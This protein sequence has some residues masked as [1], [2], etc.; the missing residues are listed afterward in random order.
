VGQHGVE[1]ATL[2]GDAAVTAARRHRC[3]PCSYA[4]RDGFVRDRVPTLAV[5]SNPFVET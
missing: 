5:H 1:C 3:S 2:T 4:A